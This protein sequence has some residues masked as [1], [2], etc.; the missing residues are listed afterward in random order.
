MGLDEMKNLGLGLDFGFTYLPT[1]QW[2]VE[3][4]LLDFGFIRHTKDLD[5]Y[6]ISGSYV[7]EGIN[8]LFPEVPDDQTAEDYWNEVA[9]N[10][11]EL[12]EVDSTATKYTTWRPT[13]LNIAARYSFGKRTSKECNCLAKDDGYLN[14]VGAQLFAINRPRAPQIALTAYYYRRLFEGLSFKT[15]YTLDSFSFTNVGL[16]VSADIG[17]VNFYVLADNILEYQ[18]LAKAQS[19]SVQFGLNLVFGKGQ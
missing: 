1:E 2:T 16:G 12:F 8:P 11:E 14:A 18:N 6:K 7:Y 3:A 15:T 13:K 19:A 10:F 9:D 17:P 4:S 5:N